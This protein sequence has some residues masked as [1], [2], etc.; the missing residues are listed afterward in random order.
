MSSFLKKHW[1]AVSGIVVGLVLIVSPFFFA[2]FRG[3][4]V[5]AQNAGQ[6]GD[7]V[8]GYY[9]TIFLF[10]SVI[11]LYVTLNAQRSASNRQSLET[12]FFE[13]VQ[14]HRD[15]VSELELGNSQGRK[16]FVLLTREFRAILEH[17]PTAGR[18]EIP[19]LSRRDRLQVAYYVLFYGTGENSSRAL[20]S[21]LAGFPP[22]F[23]DAIEKTFNDR[24]L[25][26]KVQDSRPFGYVPFE[27]HQ[28]RLGHY[29]R[30]LYQAVRY[31]DGQELTEDQKYEFVKTLRAQLTNHEQA[32]LL[33]NSLTPLGHNWWR[34]ELLIRFRMVQNIPK[35]FFNR[36]SELDVKT[37]FPEPYFEWED[38]DPAGGGVV[39]TKV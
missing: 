12:R 1:I 7:F 19:P 4:A 38:P 32:L 35:D 39:P 3:T 26:Q 5:D 27:G 29:Y 23:V 17:L 21:A 36:S 14:M 8:G 15:N 6:L 30:H 34:A 22:P 9:G 16:I 33:I 25:K 37:L 24:N 20:K 28:S 13:L 10:A 2:A 11:L 18:P 31:V